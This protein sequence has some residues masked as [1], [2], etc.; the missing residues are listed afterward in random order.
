VTSDPGGDPALTVDL[1]LAAVSDAAA[2]LKMVWLEYAD[3]TGTG[4]WQD[5]WQP[6]DVGGGQVRFV[7]TDSRLAD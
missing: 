7:R 5:A 3:D 2:A 6:R 1:E 4:R